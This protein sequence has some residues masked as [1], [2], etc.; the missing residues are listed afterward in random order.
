MRVQFRPGWA[1]NGPN[2]GRSWVDVGRMP[3]LGPSQGARPIADQISTHVD[4]RSTHIRPIFGRA[5]PAG[6]NV[7]RNWRRKCV[8]IGS[9]AG[10][11]WVEHRPGPGRSDGG[12]V[13]GSVAWCVGRLDRSVGRSG[14]GRLVG[15]SVDR[16]VS[17]VCWSVWSVYWSVWGRLVG[18]LVQGAVCAGSPIDQG[19]ERPR[20]RETERARDRATERPRGREAE[21]QRD[22]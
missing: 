2:V 15:R 13:A 19:A 11:P 1:K 9:D 22:R 14:V 4:P 10:R 8:E 17:G 12:S 7:G 3:W 16:A 18:R 6:P 20:D 5:G 21:R